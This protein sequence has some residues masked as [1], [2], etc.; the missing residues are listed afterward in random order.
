M[1]ANHSSGAHET[2]RD[3]RA[4]L[5]ML[6]T[7]ALYTFADLASKEWALDT[8]SRARSGQPPAICQPDEQGYM[9]MQRLPTPPQHF[10][11]G[12][13]D[14][15]YAENCG[16]A[17]GMLRS[18][19]GWLRALVFGVAAVGA[20]VVLLVMFVR[21]S[22]GKPFALAVPLILS[23]AVGNL[24]D[25][26]RH[27]FVVDFIQVDPKLFEYPTFNVADIA[28]TIGVALLLIDGM[29]KPAPAALTER[30]DKAVEA[31][32]DSA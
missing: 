30:T 28:I 19:P 24:S 11:S 29:K 8:L 27:G 22:G 26:V 25:R 14:M 15:H 5:L 6:A 23:G 9:D 16:A 13:L 1:S 32:E 31:S 20:S 12:V 4:L 10:I 2:R 3:A 21:G 7:L 18:A 17:F